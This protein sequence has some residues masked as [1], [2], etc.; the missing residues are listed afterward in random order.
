M[1][2]IL[3]LINRN[4]FVEETHFTIAYSRVPDTAAPNGIGGVLATVTELQI[5]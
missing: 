3:L 4:N 1:D 5:R 2:D